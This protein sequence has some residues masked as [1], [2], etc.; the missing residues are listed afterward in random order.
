MNG[1]EEI[2]KNTD[3]KDKSVLFNFGWL[4]LVGFMSLILFLVDFANRTGK[5]WFHLIAIW[6]IFVT[7]GAIIKDIINKKKLKTSPSLINK[8]K[9]EDIEKEIEL[10]E[11]GMV[12]TKEMKDRVKELKS[13]LHSN[14][15]KEVKG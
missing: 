3:E 4:K 6:L 12:Q 9:K 1:L 5:W 13:Q 15:N 7:V 8:K 14:K 11:Y 10:I 2:T